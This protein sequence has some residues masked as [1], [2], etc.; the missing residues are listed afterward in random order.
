LKGMS[1]LN[2]N[3]ISVVVTHFIFFRYV[4]CNKLGT[5]LRRFP[6]MSQELAE[7]YADN[8][9]HLAWKARGV[10]RDMN[11]LVKYK[12]QLSI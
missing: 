3:V 7:K 9:K 5:V 8:V 4:I 12:T 6:S 11:P 1:F 10:V 2:N